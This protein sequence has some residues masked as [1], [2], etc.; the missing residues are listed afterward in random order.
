MLVLSRGPAEKIVFP[1]LGITLEVLRVKGNRVRVGIQAPPNVVALRHEL[2]EK[3]ELWPPADGLSGGVSLS[4]Q[5]RNRLQTA[6]LALR[7]LQRQ[8]ESGLTSEARCT[9][10]K[11]LREFDAL[12]AEFCPIHAEVQ[13]EG[14]ARRALLVED[15]ANESELLSGYLRMSGYEVDTADDGLKALVYL[16]RHQPPDVV[17]LDM[18][19][20]QL[21]GRETIQ[22][23]RNNPELRSVKIFAVTGMS[24]EQTGVAIGPGGVDRWFR[25]PV[26]PEELVAE[27]HRELNAVS[28][29]V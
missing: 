24:R 23:I 17:L 5:Q 7:L 4:H 6:E 18:N 11:A 12:D 16:S 2:A 3:R 14:C 10:Q 29:A 21:D 28:V 9:L 26:N 22:S 19:M 13:A 15:N 8:L 25:K 27:M 1:N 20:P